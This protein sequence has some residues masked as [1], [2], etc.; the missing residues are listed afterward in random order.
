MLACNYV[1]PRPWP[2]IPFA[3]RI[4][5]IISLNWTDKT[6]DRGWEVKNWKLENNAIKAKQTAR[7]TRFVATWNVTNVEN[8]SK[9]WT[10]EASS[11]SQGTSNGWVIPKRNARLYFQNSF[12]RKEY[13]TEAN[14]HGHDILMLN[15]KL[16]TRIFV[17]FFLPM[18]KR[19]L[20]MLKKY[21]IVKARIGSIIYCKLCLFE[22]S[23]CYFAQFDEWP[24]I[25]GATSFLCLHLIFIQQL[26]QF[27]VPKLA[28]IWSPSL[29]SKFPSLNRR[30]YSLRGL[31]ITSISFQEINIF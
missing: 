27:N 4:V 11:D 30:Y 5:N 8:A 15:C 13:K 29:E 16:N 28:R 19:F 9:R 24:Q 18:E 10:R 14:V 22:N 25:G 1:K 21:R 6:E 26:L 7:S 2:D 23:M 17:Y 12:H 3:W 20:K 31:W